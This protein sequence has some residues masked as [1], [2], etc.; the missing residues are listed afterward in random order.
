MNLNNMNEQAGRQVMK[1]LSKKRSGFYTEILRRKNRAPRVMAGI[2]KYCVP[3]I[4]DSLSCGC[5]VR[6]NI[7]I[8]QVACAVRTSLHE[9]RTDNELR[10]RRTLLSLGL[11]KMAKIKTGSPFL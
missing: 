10:A 7:G 11:E 2:V 8:Q 1:G 9:N 6:A 3:R 5:P 4:A